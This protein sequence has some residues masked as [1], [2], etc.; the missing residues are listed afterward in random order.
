MAVTVA[1]AK[2]ASRPVVTDT[3]PPAFRCAWTCV[4]LH[5]AA[6]LRDSPPSAVTPA[7]APEAP[8]PALT[9]TPACQ[10]DEEA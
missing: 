6:W 5:D 8:R 4:M 7:V 1:P 9:P 2:V 3:V 10:L